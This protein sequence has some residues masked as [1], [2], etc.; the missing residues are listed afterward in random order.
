MRCM[1]VESSVSEA[2]YFSSWGI[3]MFRKNSQTNIF[4]QQKN[5]ELIFLL[6][7]L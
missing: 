6:K 5:L 1:P 4:V 3:L 7:I 2:F